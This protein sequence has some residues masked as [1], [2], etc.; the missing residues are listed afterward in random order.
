MKNT[1][2]PEINNNIIPCA[3]QM[4]VNKQIKTIYFE[5]LKVCSTSLSKM[6][7]LSEDITKLYGPSWQHVQVDTNTLEERYKDYF[8]FGFVR[9]P[10]SRMVSGYLYMKQ[11]PKPCAPE[12]GSQVP[13]MYVHPLENGSWTTL[14]FKTFT[15]LVCEKKY[16][17]KHW[18]HQLSYVPTDKI[19]LDFVGRFEN[20]DKDWEY[21]RNQIQ[22]AN[23]NF[24]GKMVHLMPDSLPRDKKYD[25]RSFYTEDLK[26]KVK[27]HY[28]KDINTF[29]Y[30]F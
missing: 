26:Q 25:Y 30:E 5:N 6:L 13:T 19:N 17:N 11:S 1:L 8:K 7:W 4:W 20:F 27:Q 24:I 23:P 12:R 16:I 29:Q 2:A 9:N 14:D 28:I 10:W 22:K 18:E 21:V 15:E 3:R